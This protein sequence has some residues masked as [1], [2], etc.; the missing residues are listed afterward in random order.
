MKEVSAPNGP[1]VREVAFT[2]YNGY[3]IV[4]RTAELDLISELVLSEIENSRFGLT[5]S[6]PSTIE[7]PVLTFVAGIRQASSQADLFIVGY[8]HCTRV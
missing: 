7:K 8:A 4:K 5:L 2:K 1:L 6:D 3:T